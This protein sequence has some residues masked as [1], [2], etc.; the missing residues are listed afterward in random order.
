LGGR[1]LLKP[2]TGKWSILLKKQKRKKKS[3]KK[4]FSFYTVTGREAQF[5]FLK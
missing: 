5:V 3:D 1:I 4:W 2:E